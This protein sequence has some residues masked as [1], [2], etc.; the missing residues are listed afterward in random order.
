MNMTRSYVLWIFVL[1]L[2]SA[3]CKKSKSSTPDP[4]I[5]KGFSAKINGT[6]WAAASI[7]FFSLT[8]TPNYLEFDGSDSTGRSIMF[9]IKNFTN[10]GT[11]NIPTA[12]DSAFYSTDFGSF[13]TVQIATSGKISIQAV[14]DS[15]VGGTFSF[16]AGSIAVTEGSFNVN[17]K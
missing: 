2:I 17:Y 4:V 7:S 1:L 9:R 8:G 11:Y 5:P 12:N 15:T 10:R 16:T 6:A 3:G 14:T 13:D